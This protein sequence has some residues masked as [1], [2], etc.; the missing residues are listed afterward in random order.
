MFRPDELQ[1]WSANEAIR[2]IGVPMLGRGDLNHGGM[3]L[4]FAPML[5]IFIFNLQ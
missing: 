1:G 2:G 4:F 5:P 3:K